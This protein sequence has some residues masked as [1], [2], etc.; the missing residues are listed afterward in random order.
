MKPLYTPEDKTRIYNLSKQGIS[1]AYAF[2]ENIIAKGKHLSYTPE[3]D[4]IALQ[5]NGLNYLPLS[6]LL[7]GLNAIPAVLFLFSPRIFLETFVV[8]A[9]FGFALILLLDNLMLKRIFS[10]L[11]NPPEK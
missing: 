11:E 9:G 6:V 2:C 3:K 5:K 7:A 4:V 10:I 1:L 8:W